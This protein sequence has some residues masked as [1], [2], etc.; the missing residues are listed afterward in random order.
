[1]SKTPKRK[2]LRINEVSPA[3]SVILII[4]MIFLAL[5]IILPLA[6]VII[7]SISST[8]S[9]ARN[10]LRY[11]PSRV[12][13]EAYRFL[14]KAG[15]TIFRSYGNT[16]FYTIV[17]TFLSLF[18]MSMFA[19]VLSLKAFKPRRVITFVAFFTTLF[20]GGLVPEYILFT[21]Y[22]HFDNTI[23]IFLLPN[24]VNA[25]YVIILRTFIQTS[26]PDSLY[27]SAKIDGANDWT[28]Y[29][30]IV[31]PLSKAGLATI[32]LFNVVE[33]WNNW[34]TGLLYVE[35][36][37]LIPIMT[38]LQR[39]Q[40]DLQYL[41]QN[42]DLAGPDAVELMKNLPSESA[43]MAIAVIAVAPLMVMYPF[44]Q[45]YFVKGMTIGSVKG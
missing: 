31:L 4:V 39:I 13:I 18:V 24:V 7:I 40:K 8:E 14:F 21:Q 22:L 43:R 20:Y 15:A 25:F 12:S 38:Y 17:G 19:Y 5:V 11:F 23:W 41:K 9:L 30:R 29:T 44:F 26:I 45:K 27:E 2:R 3:A 16:I 42:M 36:A 33:R 1:M 37:K 28:I 10:G 34:F 35:N 6:L 32:A